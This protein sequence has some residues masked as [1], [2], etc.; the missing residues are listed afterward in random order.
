MP[1]IS[2]IAEAGSGIRPLA[3]VVVVYPPR[4]DQVD[5]EFTP[6]TMPFRSWLRLLSCDAVAMT[7]VAGIPKPYTRRDDDYQEP[8]APDWRT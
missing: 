3:D 5:V 6:P 8:E 2:R 7:F 1:P 4:L